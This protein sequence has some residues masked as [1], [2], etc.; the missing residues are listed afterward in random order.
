MFDKR[1][2]IAL[3]IVSILQIWS[4][5]E[6]N[7]T[8]W[9]YYPCLSIISSSTDCLQT[10]VSFSIDE[11]I[12]QELILFWHFPV[13]NLTLD[14]FSGQNLP[15]ILRFI[16]TS[17][18]NAKIIPNLYHR[19]NDH[20]YERLLSNLN[21]H[22]ILIVPSDENHR[23]TLRFETRNKIIFDYGTFIRMTIITDH[24]NT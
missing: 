13:G 15:F 10:V 8:V 21:E 20:S 24:R 3:A 12:N 17:S 16:S 4:A 18:L 14:L 11:C 2:T 6:T 19:T 22:K 5:C 1:V 23:C 9:S 7:G